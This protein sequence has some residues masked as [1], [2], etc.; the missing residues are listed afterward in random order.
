MALFVQVL[1]M[2][3]MD[4]TGLEVLVFAL[5]R[6]LP[7]NTL[8]IAATAVVLELALLMLAMLT[9]MVATIALIVQPVAPTLVGEKTLL[10]R[11]SFLQLTA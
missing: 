1:G 4:A 6:T 10:M 7:V 2:L 5:R 9:T 8:V 11:I 3:A